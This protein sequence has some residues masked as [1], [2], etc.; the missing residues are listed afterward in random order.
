MISSSRAVASY[1]ISIDGWRCETPN[2]SAYKLPEME[3]KCMKLF[4][5]MPATNSI[6]RAIATRQFEEKQCTKITTQKTRH[7]TRYSVL[8][9]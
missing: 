9:S 4:H 1:I 6:S 8:P 5:Y 2:P 3:L 7:L